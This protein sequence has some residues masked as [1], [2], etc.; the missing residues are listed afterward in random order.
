MEEKIV[1]TV[2]RMCSAGCGMNVSVKGGKILKV[3]GLPEDPRT[4][5]ALCAKGLSAAQLAHNPD[6]LRYPMERVGTE[7]KWRRISWQ[8]ALDII[9]TK[10]E[11][12][13]Q[14]LY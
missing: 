2:C 14:R 11:G 7:D 4:K 10:L 6:R 13:K 8:Q 3:H 12:I 9:A 1:R 5:G